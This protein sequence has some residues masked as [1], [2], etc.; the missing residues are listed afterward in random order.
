MTGVTGPTGATGATGPAGATGSLGPDG[1]PLFT[2]TNNLIYPYPVVNRS[3]ALGSTTFSPADNP[4]TTATASALIH[5]NGDTGK[6]SAGDLAL[7]YNTTAPTIT[8]VGAGEDLTIS[9]VGDLYITSSVGIGTSAPNNPLDIF[10]TTTQLR[11]SYSA[12]EYGTMGVDSAG[13]LAI[14]TPNGAGNA[15]SFVSGV[16]TGATTAEAI[17]LK[18][19]QSVGVADEILQIKNNTTDLMTILGNGAVGIGNSSPNNALEVLNAT[20]PQVRVAYST[21]EYGTL[22]VDINGLLSLTTPNGAGNALSFVSGVNTGATTAEAITLKTNQ[23]VGVADEVVQIANNTTNLMTI[24]GN[25]NVGIGYTGASISEALTV[26]GNASAKIYKDNDNALYYFDPGDSSLSLVAAGDITTAAQIGIGTTAPTNAIDIIGT[27]TIKSSAGLTIDSGTG[28]LTLKPNAEVNVGGTGAGKINVG[29]VD[30]PYTIGGQRYATY[31]PSMVG[32]KEEV[33]GVA[34]TTENVPGV[35]YR[36]VIDFGRLTPGTDVW[37]F[38]KT[39]DLRTNINNLVVILNPSGNTRAWYDLDTT[40]YRLAI[41]T[42]IPSRVSYRFTAPRFDAANWKNTRTTPIEGFNI[43]GLATINPSDI[44]LATPSANIITNLAITTTATPEIGLLFDLK[45]A[46]G[47]FIYDVGQFSQAAIA[48]LKTGWLQVDTITP[49]SNNITV[50]LLGNQKLNIT[51]TAGTPQTSFDV[52]G[53]ATLS[54]QLETN[55]LVVD[56]NATIR[57]TL[58]T[59]TLYADRIITP[60]GEL[61]A[62][63]SAMYITNI[64]NLIATT[65]ADLTPTLDASTSALLA[66]LS[67]S[68][69]PFETPNIDLSGKTITADAMTLHASLSVLGGVTLGDT[70]VAGSLMI[71][72]AIQ[73]NDI[74][75]N[76]MTDTLYLNKLQLANVD[77]LAGTLVVTTE[78][79]VIVSGN[80]TVSGILGVSTIRPTTDTITLSL[81]KTASPS[82]FGKLIVKGTGEKTVTIDEQGNLTASG[83]ATVTKLNITGMDDASASTSATSSATIGAAL[84]PS[85]MTTIAVK[86]SSI[87]EQSL[88][89]VTPLSSTNNQVLYITDKIPGVG[90]TVNVDAAVAKDVQFNWWIVN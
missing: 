53:N 84:L 24:L 82:A 73:I 19:N 77:I 31:M 62:T 88:I 54:G 61:F 20:A 9:P 1:L 27:S 45:D 3:I 65:S 44:P 26:N 66:S 29:T 13:L 23:S 32:V 70:A 64:T 5:L 30:P 7:G 80:L 52:L 86:S 47:S 8:T 69:A 42:S 12:S 79:N 87:T 17:T 56:Q 16:N 18:T 75:I 63:Q 46:L 85:G 50:K 57:G 51:D 34:N 68:I 48:N 35:G 81:E 43:N 21:A 59:T 15:L 39:T 14:T 60:E 83:S 49:L 6:I 28:D 78:G 58:E 67:K 22:G 71:D 25:G 2:Q 72:A 11:L 41:Y 55:S 38:S 36:S 4:S 76:S 10:N 37:L 33:T 90:F 40:N 89:Y 74:G